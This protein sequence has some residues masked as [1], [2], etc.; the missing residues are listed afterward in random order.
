MAA[1]LLAIPAHAAEPIVDLPVAFTVQNVNRSLVP[2]PSD[3]RTCT[4]RGHLVSPVP[5]PEGVTLYL[6]G[7]SVGAFQWHL[8]SLPEFDYAT[9]MANHGHASVVIDRL[10]YDAS[11]KPDGMQ[12]CKGSSADVAHQIVGRLR[13]GAY[14]VNGGPS[15]RFDRVALGGQSQG[16]FI[17]QTE[18]FSF[19]DIDAFFQIG[20][21]RVIFGPAAFNTIPAGGLDCARGGEPVEDD[22]T[23]PG[24]YAYAWPSAEAEFRD[25]FH[26][27][28]PALLELWRPLINRDPCGED[29]SVFNAL[30]VGSAFV[31]RIEVSSL[32][33]FGEHD[34]FVP[35]GTRATEAALFTGSRDVTTAI[36]PD[37]GHDPMN[38]GSAGTFRAMMH[39]WLQAHG[40]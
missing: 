23:G 18:A 37:A 15:F 22:G 39:E 33:I 1:T 10:G 28:H 32:I 38:D 6:H 27:P 11:D 34:R 31:P 21:G 19:R 5:I 25:V 40:F 26:D 24:G 29:T 16:A 20:I 2:C 13:S 3:G 8:A 14:V 7:G 17:A 12:V 35:P 9:Q 36:I 4:V 30:V